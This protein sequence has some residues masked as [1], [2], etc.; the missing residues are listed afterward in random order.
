MYSIMYYPC[1]TLTVTRNQ[2]P[3][4]NLLGK[5][6]HHIF[7]IPMNINLIIGFLL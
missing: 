2:K 6:V 7:M 5:P 4:S 3:A 1:V